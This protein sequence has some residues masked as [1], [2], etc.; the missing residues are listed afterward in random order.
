MMGLAVA[1]CDVTKSSAGE[2]INRAITRIGQYLLIIF[3]I[4]SPPFMFM[5]MFKAVTQ[6]SMRSHSITTPFIALSG[7]DLCRPAE[8]FFQLDGLEEASTG[9]R[10]SSSVGIS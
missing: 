9:G 1:G 4:L 5:M 6:L 3:F 10:G 7:P 8:R 2:T